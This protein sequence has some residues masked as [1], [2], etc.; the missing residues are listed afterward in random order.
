MKA[1]SYGSS[2]FAKTGKAAAIKAQRSLL[3]ATLVANDW[4]LANTAVALGMGKDAMPVLRAIKRLGLTSF[5]E[6]ARAKGKIMRGGRQVV[7]EPRL[8]AWRAA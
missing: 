7:R 1:S 2:L 3:R 5:Y 6:A 8:P 4:H